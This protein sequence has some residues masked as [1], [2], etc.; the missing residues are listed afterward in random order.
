MSASLSDILTTAKNVVTAI[1]GM[2]QTYLAV[3]GAQ[4]QALISV[5]TLVKNT[6]G[7]ICTISV[8]TAGSATGTIVDSNNASNTARVIYVIPE[9]VGEYVVNLPTNYGILVIPGTSQ[10]LTVSYS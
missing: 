8:T 4:S 2:A 3:Q 7:R 10:V 9:A 5:A 1:N 6:S